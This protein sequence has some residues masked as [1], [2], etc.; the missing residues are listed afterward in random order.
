MEMAIDGF[1]P[2]SL[3]RDARIGNEERV[4]L[5]RGRAVPT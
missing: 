3:Q 2:V 4:V 1:L 5:R